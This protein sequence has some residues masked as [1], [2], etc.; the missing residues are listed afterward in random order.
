M[1]KLERES[2][3]NARDARDAWTSYC[4]LKTKLQA[5]IT[6]LSKSND[7]LVDEIGTWK[8][9]FEKFQV[10]AQDLTKQSLE[11]KHKIEAYRSENYQLSLLIKEREIESNKA[12]LLLKTTQKERDQAK[13]NL[14]VLAREK[15]ALQDQ[16]KSYKTQNHVLLTQR[17]EVENV[18]HALRTLIETQPA[19]LASMLQRKSD[20][21]RIRPLDS[22]TKSDSKSPRT[23]AVSPLSSKIVPENVSETRHQTHSNGLEIADPETLSAVHHTKHEISDLIS[24]VTNECLAALDTIK[25]VDQFPPVS[26]T[27][28]QDHKSAKDGAN[29]QRSSDRSSSAKDDVSSRRPGLKKPGYDK[30]TASMPEIR[31]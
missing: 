25:D 19:A 29:E 13:N 27:G 28:G 12:N 4:S 6:R 26:L 2:S 17:A 1:R 14:K 21:S 20:D 23:D 18:L 11:L 15:A 5:E 31:V 10:V 8:I 7:F 3:L 22:V 30:F 24:R 16:L 9:Q